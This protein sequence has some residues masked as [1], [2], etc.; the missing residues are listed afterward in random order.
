MQIDRTRRERKSGMS[1]T[2]DPVPNDRLVLCSHASCCD[3]VVGTGL[4][5]PGAAIGQVVS[6]AGNRRVATCVPVGRGA[7][8]GRSA[9]RHPRN[10]Q[11]MRQSVKI[12]SVQ[13]FFQ[14]EREELRISNRR[15]KPRAKKLRK[16]GRISIRKPFAGTLRVRI[17]PGRAGTSNRKRV[18]RGGG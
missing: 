8:S 15:N 13:W 12:Q 18:L 3:A 11:S 5:R 16:G 14:Q 4:V 6:S 10:A 9:Q 2:P 1:D 7:A 17:P